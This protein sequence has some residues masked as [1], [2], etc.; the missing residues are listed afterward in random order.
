MNV[1]QEI[2][3]IVDENDCV[4]GKA[5]RKYIHQNKL[6]HRSVHILVFNSRNELFLQKRSLLKGESPGLWDTSSAGHVDAGESYIHSAHRELWEELGLKVSLKTE[7]KF[8]ACKETHDEHI[9]VYSC[10][11]DDDISINI[12]EI[13]DGAFFSLNKV[14]TDIK[15]APHL[16]TSSFKKIFNHIQDLENISLNE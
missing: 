5:S 9:Q 12:E 6:L 10:V 2:Y 14:T 16:F 7:V 11:S 3:S 15:V 4:I 13:S 1:D 8:S